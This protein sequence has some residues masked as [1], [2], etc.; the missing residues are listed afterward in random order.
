MRA[1]KQWLLTKQET[2]TSFE[3]WRQ[4]LQYTLSLDPN[5]AGFLIDGFT[6]QNKTNAQP[7][8]S[9]VDDGEDVAE[10]NRR[11]APKNVPILN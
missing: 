5:F 8:Q 6:W 11:T 4:N 1:P 10:A 9:F 2:I 7:L 3:A